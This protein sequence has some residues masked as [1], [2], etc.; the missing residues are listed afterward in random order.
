MLE[1]EERRDREAD[2]VV[3]DPS[4]H[5]DHEADAAR[6]AFEAWVVQALAFG[7]AGGHASP[8]SR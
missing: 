3:A 8:L 1:V 7:Y 6:V 4:L 2:D 5:V